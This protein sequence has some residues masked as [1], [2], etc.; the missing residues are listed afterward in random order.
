MRL[1]ESPWGLFDF[2]AQG[3]A[4][5]YYQPNTISVWDTGLGKTHLAMALAA[6]LFEDDLI[7]H[8]VIVAERNKVK[9]D[10]WPKDIDT[11]TSLEWCLYRGTPAQRAKMR[12]E[13]PQ[14]II[15]TY[16]TLRNDIAK[17][18]KVGGRKTKKWVV[19]ELT[20]V[21][22]GKRVLVVYDEMTK[23]GN[24][25][26]G[27]HKAHDLFIS[28]LRKAGEC[29]VLGLTATPIE[30][31]P[32]S[33]YNL[34]RI[35]MP[36][37]MTVAQFHQD[38]I[39]A[40]DYFGNPTRWKNLG[41]DDHLDPE[42]TTFADFMAPIMLRKRKSDPDVIDQFPKTVEEFSFIDLAPIQ[43]DFYETVIDTFEEQIPWTV[44]RQ[45]AA[46]PMSL[47]RSQGQIAQTIVREVGEEGLRSIPSA[48]T[49][50]LV[51]Y[52]EPLVQ[53]QGAQVVVFTFFVS[54]VPYI[55]EAIRMAGMEVVE[56]HGQMDD[57]AQ[58]EA[59]RLFRSGRVPIFLS[60]DAGARGINLPEATYAVEYEMSLTHAMR[61]QRLNRIHRIDST[62]PSVTFMSFIARDTVEEG[63]AN[64][65]IRRNEWSDTILDWDDP[66]E[67]FMT[68]EARKKMLQVARR[69]AAV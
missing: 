39:A 14:V 1:Y 34:G 28:T 69:R 53:G 36:G 25:G 56:H 44:A 19:N 48:K 30:R 40:F 59:K 32:E 62:A 26:S 5:A 35:F 43:Y 65:V 16:E 64:A 68:A 24:R 52:L 7:D 60:T 63:I 10:E 67:N 2:Q 17:Q 4:K 27:L 66:G 23:L 18:V 45:I 20:E 11:F 12:Q 6:L 3:V 47:L 38:Y 58:E 8:V 31:S 37:Y 41:E 13:L 61:T 50:A 51:E 22:A 55:A 57:A 9:E 42:V 15:S 21:L 29:R 46:H 49:Q 54:A 33:F